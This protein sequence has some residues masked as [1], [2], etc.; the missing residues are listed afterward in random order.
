MHLLLLNIYSIKEISE[1]CAKQKRE[2]R[3]K[4]LFITKSW[5]K[6]IRY[7]RSCLISNW[8]IE[9][10]IWSSKIIRRTGVLLYRHWLLYIPL[11]LDTYLSFNLDSSKRTRRQHHYTSWRKTITL[12]YLQLEISS[13]FM[14]QLERIMA[15]HIHTI[16]RGRRMNIAF[17]L[18]IYA[19]FCTHVTQGKY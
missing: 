3:K 13:H 19:I 11:I 17:F 2:K 16:S 18:G 4:Y 9:S 12:I 5:S 8:M 15:Y 1:Y 10:R 14:M 7:Y 6:K